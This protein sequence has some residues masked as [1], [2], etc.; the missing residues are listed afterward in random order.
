MSGLKRRL[1][2]NEAGWLV[3]R[4]GQIFGRLVGMTIELP[5]VGGDGGSS[6]S[7]STAGGKEE[8]VE[9]DGGAG[10]THEI[11]PSQAKVV[12]DHYCQVFADVDGVDP[13]RMSLNATRARVIRNALKVRPV[14]VCRA[15]IE[16]LAR[17]PWHLGQNEDGKK[18]LDIRYALKGNSAR[19]ESNEERIDK[20]CQ[21]AAE[22]PASREADTSRLPDGVSREMVIRRLED[23]RAYISSGRKR[24]PTRAAE[25]FVKF[26]EWGLIVVEHKAHPWATLKWKESSDG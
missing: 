11:A 24:E 17:S 2:V 20:M 8:G 10:E 26:K 4:D 18:Y 22:S 9:R 21:L 25:A 23:V 5:P 12:W 3:D 1:T 15:A 14:A 13:S 7:S 16:G 6:T 19:G